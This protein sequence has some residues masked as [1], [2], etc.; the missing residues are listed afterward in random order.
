MYHKLFY[1]GSHLS[2]EKVVTLGI[3]INLPDKTLSLFCHFSFR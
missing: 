3:L 2:F 1:F